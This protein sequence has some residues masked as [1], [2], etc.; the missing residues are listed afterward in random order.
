M[1]EKITGPSISG[2]FTTIIRHNYET[3][4]NYGTKNYFE[5]WLSD[6]QFLYILKF[7]KKEDIR[8]LQSGKVACDAATYSIITASILAVAKVFADVVYM[9]FLFPLLMV[10]TLLLATCCSFPLLMISVPVVSS[11][12]NVISVPSVIE[13]PFLLMFLQVLGSFCSI[14]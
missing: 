14:P 4:K 9:M 3:P 5:T 10:L 12:L 6:C 13:I 2:L 11:I 8:G 1:G 7:S